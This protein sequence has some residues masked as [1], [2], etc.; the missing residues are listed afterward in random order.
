MTDAD[1]DKLDLDVARA[2]IAAGQFDIKIADTG[3]PTIQAADGRWEPFRP[4]VNAAHAWPIIERERIDIMW[5][6][7]P[8]LVVAMQMYLARQPR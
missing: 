4:T 5:D 3:R 7:R 6:D 8:G 2:E 1:Y